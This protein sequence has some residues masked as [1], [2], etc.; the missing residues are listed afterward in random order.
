MQG[1]N[2]CSRPNASVLIVAGEKT[3]DAAEE[4]FPE[5]VAITWPGGTNAVRKADWSVLKGREVVIW[6]DAD[7]PGRKA[8]R[9]VA[10]MARAAGALDVV[11]VQGP[12][13]LP[14][15]WDLADPVPDGLD[16]DEL[17]AGPI[18]VQAEAELPFGFALTS[19]GL[20]WTLTVSSR[21]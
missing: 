3:A 10:L 4:R 5:H 16:L 15:G 2:S 6:P 12:E 14:K 20:V 17:L 8:S 19:K 11:I 13:T 1:V 18:P 7:E 9:D 21:I